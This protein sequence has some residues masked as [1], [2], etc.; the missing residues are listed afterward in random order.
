MSSGLATVDWLIIGGYL[1]FAL[2]VG[3]AV[4][5]RSSEDL[6][7]YFL[8]GRALPWWWAG[9]SIAATM[10]AADTPLAVTGIVADKGLG[11]NWI[12]LSWGVLH[13]A[14]A[15]FFADRWQRS[16]VLTD[17][18]L[19]T[20]RYQG[21]WAG[22]LRLFRAGLYGLVINAIILGW[23]LRAM[24]T[25][26][27]PYFH[28]ESWAPGLVAAVGA[29]LPAG[30]AL[31]A[32]SEAI[33]IVTLVAL[34]GAYS[35][36]GGIRGVILTD[37]VQLVMALFGS[38]AFAWIA[39]DHA[40]G[41]AALS[42]GA[43]AAHPSLDPTS[44]AP[45]MVPG[46]T[47]IVPIAAAVTALYLFAQSVSNNPA[48][49]GGFFMQRLS[50]CRSPADARRAAGWFVV[51][52]YLVRPWPWFVVAL[53]ALVLIPIGGEAGAFGGE[54]AYVADSREAGYA[55]LIAVLV[56]AGLKGL[57]IASLLA[58][59]MSTV[60][61]HINWGASY[62]VNDVYKRLRP[63]ASGRQAMRVSRLAAL[64]LA[65]VA[66]VSALNIGSIEG[67]WKTVAA[68][69]AGIAAPTAL[70]WLWWR[71]TAPAE[72]ASVLAGV[73]TWA[74]T[75]LLAPG[76]GYELQLITIFCAGAAA[77]VAT[78]LL[79]PAPDPETVRRFVERVE[80]IGWW[81]GS[82]RGFADVAPR[83]AAFALL[84]TALYALLVGGAELLFGGG[85]G[86]AAWLAG[87]L[88]VAVLGWRL[89]SESAAREGLGPGAPA[90]EAVHP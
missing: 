16:G 17:A 30:S 63:D 23:V 25:I 84:V 70:R 49:G 61:T 50:T 1:G 2:A 62:L 42:A 31:G 76:L 40:G 12:W 58:A 10:F 14:V 86:G 20:L 52:N 13:V 6:E 9:T 33:T 68:I 83:L 64:F 43:A 38:F 15:C 77:G 48:D 26:V 80:P 3:V 35:A 67:A 75:S 89:L 7:S 53:A 90:S 81:P 46:V 87:G 11:G 22:R 60:D 82:R 54:V 71:I 56:P 34:V 74:L 44:L 32:P 59:F 36:L 57:L 55:A 66:V 47:G 51:L 5:R 8:A 79:G 73:G 45:A 78:A 39:V 88:A 19:V 18:E 27:E 72:I 29:V 85:L 65:L 41:L 21:A 4:S 69:G 37:L 28:W 24:T